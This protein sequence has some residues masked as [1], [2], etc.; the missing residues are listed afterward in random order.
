AWRTNG[1]G[2][3]EEVALNFESGVGCL[4]L[5]RSSSAF[6][7]P[8]CYKTASPF[9]SGSLVRNRDS[10]YKKMSMGTSSNNMRSSVLEDADEHAA[11]MA[12]LDAF[13]DSSS[14]DESLD[15]GFLDLRRVRTVQKIP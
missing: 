12:S 9:G 14:S 6:C 8:P 3:V 13:S 7:L 10:V 4:L 15:F 11:L 1:G 5:S 2:R